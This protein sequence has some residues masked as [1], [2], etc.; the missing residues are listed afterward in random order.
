M[1][2]PIT[3]FYA[4]LLAAFYLFLAIMVIR[5]RFKSNVSLGHG[6]EK[7]MLQAMRAHGNFVEYVPFA[8]L[9]MMMAEMNGAQ[10][11]VLHV[12]GWWLIA[13]R[14]LHAHGVRFHFGPNWQRLVGM[15]ST[16]LILILLI[17]I[18]MFQIYTLT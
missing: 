13:A 6:E 2:V 15:L 9:L 7:H 5:Q 4:C 1:I 8:L 12:C 11:L 3:A 10:H 17:G 16:F 18:N 14:F